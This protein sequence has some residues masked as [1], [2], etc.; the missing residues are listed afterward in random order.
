MIVARFGSF[1]L[2][3]FFEVDESLRG[4]AGVP[5]VDFST[6]AQPAGVQAPTA[7]SAAPAVPAEPPAPPAGG[8]G[9]GGSAP[10]APPG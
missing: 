3:E 1:Q 8:G 9:G 4:D 10:P 7:E 5:R 2:E 6:M